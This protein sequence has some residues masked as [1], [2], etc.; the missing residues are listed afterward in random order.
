MK[1]SIFLLKIISWYKKLILDIK[2]ITILYKNFEFLK[3]RNRIIDIQK[4]NPW[5]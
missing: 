3:S 1:K 5:Y 4:S 2:K